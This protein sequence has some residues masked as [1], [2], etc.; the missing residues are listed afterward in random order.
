MMLTALARAVLARARR[1]VRLPEALMWL[2]GTVAMMGVAIE[3]SCW[4]FSLGICN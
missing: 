3:L 2:G 1:R 4:F